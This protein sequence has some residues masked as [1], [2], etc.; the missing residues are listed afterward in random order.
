MNGIFDDSSIVQYYG[1]GIVL[2]IV[3]DNDSLN[4]NF[5]HKG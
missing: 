2:D 3:R 5:V 1:L 4:E